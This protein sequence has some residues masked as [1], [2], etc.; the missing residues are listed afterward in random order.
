MVSYARARTNACSAIEASLSATPTIELASKT[1]F[2]IIGREFRLDLLVGQPI[3]ARRG[4]DRGE[5]RSQWILARDC[6]R[7]M[8]LTSFPMRSRRLGSQSAS[9]AC[10]V[11]GISTIT[12]SAIS[13]L[14]TN[15]PTQI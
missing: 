2:G 11:T 9:A 7:S 10:G 5:N 8:L 3:G 12:V 15:F 13:R 1:T 4:F 14:T 6:G